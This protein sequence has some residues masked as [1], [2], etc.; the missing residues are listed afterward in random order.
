MRGY[1]VIK[2]FMKKMDHVGVLNQERIGLQS[3]K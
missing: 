1:N 3:W 2:T